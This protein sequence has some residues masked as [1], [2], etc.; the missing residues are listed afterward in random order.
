MTSQA[1]PVP[2]A[3][4]KPARSKARRV[5][6]IALLVLAVPLALVL[7]A[8]GWL[9]SASGRQ[10]VRTRIE[11]RLGERVV[12]SVRIGRLDYGLFG[13]LVLGGVALRDPAGRDVVVLDELVVSPSWRD[14]VRGSLVVDRVALTGLHLFIVQDEAGGSNLKSL[15]K[16]TPPT[17]PSAPSAPPKERRIEVR[18][19]VLRDIDVS[20]DKPDGT[21]L[22]LDDLA[23]DARVEA[24]PVK[25]RVHLEA[26]KIEASLRLTKPGG[27]E[28]A[29]TRLATGLGVDLDGGAG[30][31]RLAPT[32]AH[33]K[34]T[35]PG[36]GE[37]RETDIQLN[38]VELQVAE[39][40]LAASLDH[41]LVGAIVLEALEVRGKAKD[42]ALAGGQK[43]EML[44]LH[45]DAARLNGLLQRELLASDVDIDARIEGPPER[46]V[47]ATKVTTKGGTV[48]LDGTFDVSNLARP[49]FDATLTATEIRTDV[50]LVEGASKAPPTHVSSLKVGLKGR[51]KS[52]QDAEAAITVALG[53]TTVGKLTVDEATVEAHLARGE[54]TIDKIVVKVLGQTAN[55][56]GKLNLA[57]KHVTG[58][59][60]L[61]ADAG[62]ATARARAAGLPVKAS[63]PPGKIRLRE[64]DLVV[65]VDG[66]LE[67]TLAVD[68]RAP[69]IALAGGT[70][71]VAAHAELA[72]KEPGEDGRRFEPKALH[73][74][75]DL[76]EIDIEEV[77]ALR[78]KHMPPGVD[79]KV[80]GHVVVEG[81]PDDPRVDAHTEVRARIGGA[82]LSLLK[83]STLLTTVDA[84]ASKTH[85]DA[86]IAVDRDD[87]NARV[88]FLSVEAHAPIVVSKDYKGLGD[89]PI[90]V[91]IDAPRRSFADYLAIVPKPILTGLGVKV[92]A[93]EI[94]AHA[95]VEGTRRQPIGAFSF[96]GSVAAVGGKTQR[97]HLDGT[98]A[99][100]GAGTD[101]AARATAWLDTGDSPLLTA[102]VTTG[103]S[104]SPLVPG[105]KDARWTLVL[106]VPD[107]SLATLPL[108]PEKL[109]GLAGTVGLHVDLKGDLSDAG[110]TAD[111]RVA[112]LKKGEA[113]PIALT[114]HVAVEPERTAVD[115][116]AKL[117][118][119][120]P[121]EL[122]SLTGSVGL[123][124]KGLVAAA[125]AKAIGD[126]SLD[127][128]LNVPRR[129][130]SELRS[131]RAALAALPGVLHGDGKIGGTV[132][133]PLADVAIA[134]DEFPTVAGETGKVALAI[135]A[136]ADRVG[137]RVGLGPAQG[138]ETAPVTVEVGAPRAAI[139]QLRAGDGNL[140]VELAAHASRVDV[141]RL[142]PAFAL[143]GRGVEAG[144]TLDWDMKGRLELEPTD[145]GPKLAHGN[146]DGTL[147]LTSGRA[148]IPRSSRVWHD[149][150]LR[151]SA[152][153]DALRIDEIALHESDVQLADRTARI[154][155]EIAWADLKPKKLAIDVRT[156][157]WLLFGGDKL[158][159]PDAPRGTV[160]VDLHVAGDLTKPMRTI[161]A[162]VRV[163]SLAIPERFPRAHAP[164]ILHLGD[165]AFVSG[166]RPGEAVGVVG[167]LPVPVKAEAPKPPPEPIATHES[168]D[169][170]GDAPSESEAGGT[171]VTVR[172]PNPV[173]IVNA[174]MTLDAKGELT[175]R[176]AGGE[177][178]VR[179]RVEAV[180]GHFVLAGTKHGLDRGAIVFDDAHPQGVM[181]LHFSRKLQ[182]AALRDMSEASAGDTVYVDLE[183]PI[184]K[185][186]MTL[187]GAGNALLYD[188][189]A[190]EIARRPRIVGK[191]DLP[192]TATAQVPGQTDL[193]GL[194]YMNINLP[195]NLFLDRIDAWADPYDMPESYG[196][197]RH[198]EADRYS[199]DGKTRVRATARPPV[200]GRSDAEIELDWLFSNTSR[201]IF[202]VG[203]VGG[204]RL[205][206]GPAAFIE[207]SSKD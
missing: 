28:L 116:R 200:A 160:D 140:P 59:L 91:K 181:D 38:Q 183:G 179:G 108:P 205:G 130:M 20:L 184:S 12:G 95:T 34:L 65:D 5:A 204:N 105:P 155:G 207:W 182:V 166:A 197:L 154:S 87:G 75:I 135:D 33:A 196:R 110:G 124:G 56:S 10:L 8:V 58:R 107:R 145:K 151:L 48:T 122:V 17:P 180:G 4:A 26:A 157:Q 206:G 68:V 203:V 3:A 29:V 79:A 35:L 104:K 137:A 86:H 163:L 189:L 147:A 142:V 119:A 112:N 53:P 152:N 51:G 6:R 1:D 39:G 199:E 113:G 191:P 148:T 27:L 185:P 173:H 46:I 81:T 41:L 71:R 170:S 78:G 55:L 144:G 11:A 120:K 188:V 133:Q 190:Q 64:G 132:K 97:I 63:L 102:R 177:R 32:S 74:R 85:V 159:Q 139:A 45:L 2:P 82:G 129:P 117:P 98:L 19:I 187:R 13:D 9:H 62:V 54:L 30:K 72:R 52:K 168:G 47:L 24:T 37:P 61:I 22:A 150:A 18:S 138:S 69:G 66:D 77:L 121:A 80:S 21:H 101:V 128:A 114:A 194:T 176:I 25:K 161:D 44:G 43:A 118:E 178:K 42:G 167:K 94:E 174:P 192:A 115:V 141:R 131:L 103:L 171:L 96:D 100:N 70:A 186:K 149:I 60:G 89:G 172:I 111:V 165:V 99:P 76:D 153:K 202:G 88:S 146:V 143:E 57:S 23:I 84:K 90:S 109:E 16:P 83:T 40:E 201:T 49:G 169:E 14:L 193:L 92:P 175:I 106:D 127:L 164:E 73:A 125:R 15:F 36:G 50:L 31:I 67:G 162:E 134:W 158:G 198:L 126:P 93:G 156:K 136:T 123:P 7:L 195:H